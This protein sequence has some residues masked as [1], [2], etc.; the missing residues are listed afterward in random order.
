MAFKAVKKWRNSI[1]RA[2][3]NFLCNL[4]KFY[5]S[6]VEGLYCFLEKTIRARKRVTESVT[7]DR[8]RGIYRLLSVRLGWRQ[9]KHV[10]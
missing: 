10:A 1:R 7:G 9:I 3:T 8:Q 5:L 6:I 4:A 2:N